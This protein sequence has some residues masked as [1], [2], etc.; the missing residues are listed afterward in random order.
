MLKEQCHEDF[1]DLGQ[2]CA[3]SALLWGFDHTQNASVNLYD[4]D[5]KWI[6]SERANHNKYLE[7]F[8][9]TLHQNSKKLANF[10]KF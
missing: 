4:R 8:W 10:I 9:N 7:D 3:K 6:L 2:F 5:I 1:A